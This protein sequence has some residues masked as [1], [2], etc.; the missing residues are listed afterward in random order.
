MTGDT[1]A[2][3]GPHWTFALRL[4]GQPGVAEACLLLQ[5]RLGVDV[6]VLLLSAYA[7]VERGIGLDA[8]DLRDMDSLVAPWHG[9][10]V[11]GLRQLRRRLKSGP[12]PAP[13][14]ATERLRTQIKS[15]ELH[16]E[17][18]EQAVLARWLDRRCAGRQPS[19]VDIGHA[20]QTVVAYFAG[21]H[22]AST[23]TAEIRG[24]MQ[25]LREAVGEARPA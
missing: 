3:D 22:G 20:L 9:E 21:G 7:A 14:E 1:L 2:L 13:C 18:I 25:A 10:I 23:D 6:N 24:A 11:A 8:G 15:A 12:A 17:Q 5:D 16:A 4:Y 19:Q